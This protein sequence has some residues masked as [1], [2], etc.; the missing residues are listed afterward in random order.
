M[1][2]PIDISNLSQLRMVHVHNKEFVAKTVDFAHQ[3]GDGTIIA[4]FDAGATHVSA[5]FNQFGEPRRGERYR[6]KHLSLDSFYAI[7]SGTIHKCNGSLSTVAHSSIEHCLDT[8]RHADFVLRINPTK[9]PRLIDV[10]KWSE[11]Y[12]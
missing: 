8:N 3:F 6:L 10:K 11:K 12:G 5:K 1:L 4:G 2:E 7:F 9:R